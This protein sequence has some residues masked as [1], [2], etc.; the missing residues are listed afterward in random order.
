MRVLVVE[1][2]QPLALSVSQGLRE[3]GYAVDTAADGEEHRKNRLCPDDFASN[4]E[5]D[6]ISTFG[7]RRQ[8]ACATACPSE[9]L[10]H[11]ID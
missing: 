8:S 1:D 6:D 7:M 3:A 5:H 2:Y 10:Q 11:A 9:L 4:V